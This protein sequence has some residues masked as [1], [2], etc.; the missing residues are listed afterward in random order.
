MLIMSFNVF[1]NDLYVE[2][3]GDSSTV[4]ITQQGSGNR[5]GTSLDSVYIGGGSNTVNLNQQGDNNELDMVVNGASTNTTVT[6][7]GSGNI[8]T[9]NCGTTAS[10]GC[11]S[12]K[13]TQTIKG[14]TNTVTQSLG[15]GANHTSNIT[16]TGDNNGVTHKEHKQWYHFW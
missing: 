11:S 4:N 15:T 5:M 7:I 12:S 8:Q 1:A 13:I 9:I 10:A 3:V 16:V 6:T 2:Q 14:D